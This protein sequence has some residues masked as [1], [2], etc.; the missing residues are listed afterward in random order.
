MAAVGAY[1]TDWQFRPGPQRAAAFAVALVLH[2]ALFVTLVQLLGGRSASYPERVPIRAVEVVQEAALAPPAP[3]AATAPSAADQVVIPER[4]RP[5]RPRPQP[6]GADVRPLALPRAPGE[7][8]FGALGGL[9][10]RGLGEERIAGIPDCPPMLPGLLPG[11]GTAHVWDDAAGRILGPA[12]AG[13]TLFD[14]ALERG[15]INPPREILPEFRP[16]E[17]QPDRGGG[18]R[19]YGPGPIPSLTE[20]QAMPRR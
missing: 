8:A 13:R 12:Y 16:R 5:R 2:V 1:E 9:L 3:S 19:V 18:D 7:G 15:W 6:L 20:T 4:V 14:V 17:Q 10:C 11:R